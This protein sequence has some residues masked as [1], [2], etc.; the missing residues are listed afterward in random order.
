MASFDSCTRIAAEPKYHLSH[1]AQATKNTARL[2]WFVLL[3]S[4]SALIKFLL[5]L[6]KHRFGG[7]SLQLSEHPSFLTICGHCAWLLHY[8]KK[9]VK[10]LAP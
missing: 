7:I 4:Q 6:I 8:R 3:A 2:L 10:L 5:K 9:I 1:T